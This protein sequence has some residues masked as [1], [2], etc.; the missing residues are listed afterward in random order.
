MPRYINPTLNIDNDPL[1]KNTFKLSKMVYTLDY[2]NSHNVI[3]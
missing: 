1:S 3:I 2:L